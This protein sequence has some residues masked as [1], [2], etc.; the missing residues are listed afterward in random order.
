MCLISNIFKLL[1]IPDNNCNSLDLIKTGKQK[2]YQIGQ[3]CIFLLLKTSNNLSHEKAI[4]I[5]Y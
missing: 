3:N 1:L 2:M 5:K 4:K